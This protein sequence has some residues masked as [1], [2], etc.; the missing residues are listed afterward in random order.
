MFLRHHPRA[1]IFHAD[2]MPQLEHEEN[3]HDFYFLVLA[4]M[5]HWVEHLTL[6]GFFREMKSQQCAVRLV[7]PEK[8]QLL[9][10][11]FCYCYLQTQSAN[12]SIW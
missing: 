10:I 11:M 9:Y 2:I 4:H 8:L 3:H 1:T 5:F 12:G 7:I 6:F